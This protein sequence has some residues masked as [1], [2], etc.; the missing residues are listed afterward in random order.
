M[1]SQEA[2]E[3]MQDAWSLRREAL[4]ANPV[5]R[6]ELLEQARAELQR[7]AEICRDQ[8]ACVDYAQAIHMTAKIELDQDHVERARELWE[9]AIG[10]LRKTDD[11]LQ[12]AHKVR[13]LGDLHERC[14]RSTD[15]EGCYA[16][17]LALYHEHDGAGSIDY[18][19]AVRRMAGLKERSGDPGEALALWRETRELYDAVDLA[20]GV[21][22][23]ER[24]ILRLTS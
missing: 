17:A 10:I 9:R 5:R 7:A 2:Q 1:T 20:P 6:H 24:R 3:L 8:G 22:E 12:L 19:N 11:A 14:G 23:A 21:E 4:E 16:E 13:H 18:A 15:A